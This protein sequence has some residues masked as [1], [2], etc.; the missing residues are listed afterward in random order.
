MSP[1]KP[2]P[3]DLQAIGLL[4]ERRAVNFKARQVETIF[5]AVARRESADL[6][7][8]MFHQKTVFLAEGYFRSAVDGSLQR[9][10]QEL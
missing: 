3:G 7:V 2:Y 1:G 9:R 5:V 10:C 4:I 6:Q 8:P